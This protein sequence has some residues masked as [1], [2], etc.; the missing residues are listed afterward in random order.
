[1][2]FVSLVARLP[3]TKRRTSKSEWP[4]ACRRWGSMVS[5]LP[6]RPELPHWVSAV[7]D[8][9]PHILTL[10][11]AILCLITLLNLRGTGEAGIAFA[12][13]TYLFITC[14]LGM[15][16]LGLAKSLTSAGHL[17]AV[18]SPP[19]LPA[20]IE[21][22][23]VWI[24]RAFAS[25]CTAMTGVEAVSNGVSAFRRPTISHAYRTLTIIVVLLAILSEASPISRACTML[26]LSHK[27][28]PAKRYLTAYTGG[29][30]S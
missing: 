10:C 29:G 14:M 21:T 17:A 11:L 12:L 5:R 3:P 7:P 20:A 15:L 1:M 13:P 19:E 4:P 28:R 24:M 23:G 26:A 8:L 16:G 2:S 6:H 27:T 9:H 25:G 18:V 30:G 22:A